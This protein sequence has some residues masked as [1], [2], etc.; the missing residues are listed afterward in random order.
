MQDYVVPGDR[1]EMLHQFE[2][3]SVSLRITFHYNS[4]E[5][6]FVQNVHSDSRT[7]EK[8]DDRV[9]RA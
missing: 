3:D 6:P 2:I 7:S 4:I 1:A 5:I 9:E 8:G